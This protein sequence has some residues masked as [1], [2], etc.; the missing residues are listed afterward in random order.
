[1]LLVTT[2][3]R[4]WPPILCLAMTWLWKWSTMISDLSRIAWSLPSTKARSFFE[5]RRASNSGS[6][7]TVFISL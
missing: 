1:M 5:A 4:A 6:S 2:M 7:S 3:A